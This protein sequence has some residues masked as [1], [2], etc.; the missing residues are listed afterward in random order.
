MKI[1]KGDN[2]IVISGID[3]GKTGK[4]EKVFSDTNK[5]VVA[6]INLRKRHKKARSQKEKNEIIEL[7]VPINASRVMIF[8]QKCKKG[9]R[10]GINGVGKD[11]IRVCKKCKEAI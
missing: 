3:K 4:I 2:I 9:T 11:K 7:A 10:I 5:I 6:G 1:K 8:C